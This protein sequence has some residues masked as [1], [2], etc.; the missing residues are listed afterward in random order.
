MLTSST[1]NEVHVHDRH[2]W[3]I[4]CCLP[5]T[6]R[7]DFLCLLSGRA[8]YYY[9][10]KTKSWN[11]GSQM[12]P[13]YHSWQNL[14]PTKPEFAEGFVVVVSMGGRDLKKREC[15]SHD[16]SMSI[17]SQVGER[18]HWSADSNRSCRKRS[19]VKRTWRRNRT[20]NLTRQMHGWNNRSIKLRAR[21]SEGKEEKGKERWFTICATTNQNSL[22]LARPCRWH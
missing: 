5:H 19:S 18:Q 22:T 7:C 10:V 2:E 16:T 17:V 4:D 9:A 21:R 12:C 8:C 14:I 11:F 13:I 1:L 6:V 3:M 20:S 15:N